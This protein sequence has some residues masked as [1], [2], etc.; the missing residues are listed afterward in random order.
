MRAK[1]A[2]LKFATG[3]GGARDSWGRCCCVPSLGY[4]ALAVTYRGPVLPIST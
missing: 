3:G 1:P 4:D 2:V